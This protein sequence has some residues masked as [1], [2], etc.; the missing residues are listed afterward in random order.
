[1]VRR[2]DIEPWFD[3]SAEPHE[4]LQFQGSIDDTIPNRYS[5]TVE[6]ITKSLALK[7]A[8]LEVDRTLVCLQVVLINISANSGWILVQFK[9]VTQ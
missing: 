6:Q 4:V 9:A 7:W 1:M 2:A 5:Y 3:A 8:F